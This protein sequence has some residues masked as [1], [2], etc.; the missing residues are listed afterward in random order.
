MYS[1]LFYKSYTPVFK[2]RAFPLISFFRV[3]GEGTL[4]RVALLSQGRGP[5]YLAVAIV[6]PPLQPYP[7]RYAAVSVCSPIDD[8]DKT[9][10]DFD[11]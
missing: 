10:H 3:R 9:P 2:W 11:F 6:A 5:V 7:L 4:Q 1:K 8:Q